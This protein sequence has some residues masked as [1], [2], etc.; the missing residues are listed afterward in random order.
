VLWETEEP[1]GDGLLWS[2]LTNN[3]LRVSAPG[4]PSLRNVLT[5]VRLVADTPHGLSGEIV[6]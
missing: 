5:P 6:G 2:G 4:G 3:Y 1:N